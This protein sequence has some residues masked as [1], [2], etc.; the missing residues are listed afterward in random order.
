MEGTSIT[1]CIIKNK[2]KIK[3]I[4]DIWEGACHY[5]LFKLYFDRR[6][7]FGFKKYIRIISYTDPHDWLWEYDK[8]KNYGFEIDIE[9]PTWN[10]FSCN[11]YVEIE[12]G[13]QVMDNRKL[14]E[15]LY[16]VWYRDRYNEESSRWQK[17]GKVL[18][19]NL[20]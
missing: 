1:G 10:I 18:H 3:Y 16:D 6:N 2:D 14:S 19:K 13:N 4:T 9:F 5:W 20:K 12:P 7:I 17:L 11:N 8:D 15:I